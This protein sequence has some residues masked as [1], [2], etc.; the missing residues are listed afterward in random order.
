MYRFSKRSE[1]NLVGVHPDL[2]RVARRALELTDVD[3]VVIDG[4][5]TPEE[6]ALYLK[7]GTSWSKNS[8]HLTGH[9][10]DFAVWPITWENALYEHVVDAFKVAALE[11]KIPIVC[12]RDW[13][14]RD[15]GHIE[16]DR[17]AY[18]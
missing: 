13:K 10:I 17:R 12:G 4:V 8:R 11:L 14:V 6:Q 9:A 7:K 18:P 2:V 16:L 1:D 5:R 3:F 15:D